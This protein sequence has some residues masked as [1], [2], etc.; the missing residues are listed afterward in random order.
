MDK[1]SIY[2]VEFKMSDDVRY[3][4]IMD[5][6]GMEKT[7]YL[8]ANSIIETLKDKGFYSIEEESKMFV[9]ILRR[10]MICPVDNVK[11]HVI[12]YVHTLA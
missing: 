11:S 12:A 6:V 5:V 4:Q 9:A 7:L 1:K 8:D 2:T 10:D 3:Y